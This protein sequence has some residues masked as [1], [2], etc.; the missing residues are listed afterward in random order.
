MFKKT[1]SKRGSK[2]KFPSL[3]LMFALACAH[4][5]SRPAVSFEPGASNLPQQPI[6]PNDLLAISVYDAPELTRTIR[7]SAEGSIRVPMLREK[8]RASGL[9]P[10]DL[11]VSVATALKSEKVLVEPIVTIM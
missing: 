8:I 3:F 10:A 5:Q 9:M 1:N 2:M 6:G 7:V 4:G 11:E